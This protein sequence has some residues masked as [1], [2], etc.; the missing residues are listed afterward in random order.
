MVKKTLFIKDTVAVLL[1][2][3]KGYTDYLTKVRR[4][5]EAKSETYF[6][7][8]W[9]LNLSAVESLL[10]STA[11]YEAAASSAGDAGILRC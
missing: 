1:F 7:I 8:I 11:G 5:E 6:W 4:K 10:P 2:H 3:I 9:F